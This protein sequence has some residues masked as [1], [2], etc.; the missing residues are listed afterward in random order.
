MRSIR[1]RGEFGFKKDMMDKWLEKRLSTHSYEKAGKCRCWSR[2]W[3]FL[4]MMPKSS[5]R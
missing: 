3:I 2:W 4:R 1:I 5:L